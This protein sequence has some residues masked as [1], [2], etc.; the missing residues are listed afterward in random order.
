MKHIF[1][2]SACALAIWG[3]LCGAA[4]AIEAGGVR[5]DDQISV[6][7]QS[8]VANGAGVRSRFII[9]VYAMAL[10]LPAK[11]SNADA[12]LG[13]SGPARIALQL[14]R[15]LSAETF[16]NALRDG[17][18]ENLSQAELA[19]ISPQMEQFAKILAEAKEV[20][21][22]TRVTIDYLPASGTRV[23]IGGQQKGSDIAGEA[24]Y[25]GLLKIWLGA[26][27]VQDNLK[28]K[29]LGTS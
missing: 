16:I 3:T 18:K 27:P 14:M 9:D 29:L 10:Y 25:K 1:Q 23:S 2:R 7:G 6:G 24:F 17:L 19:A 28:A 8:L 21:K 5:F 12:V 4:L 11:A 20:A 26:K 13:Q 22:G 15:D